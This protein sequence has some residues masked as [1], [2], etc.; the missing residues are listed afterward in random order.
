MNPADGPWLYFVTVNL[1]TGETIFTETYREHLR[2]V[3]QWQQWCADN[4]DAGC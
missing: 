3:D 4:P 2:Y 1:N